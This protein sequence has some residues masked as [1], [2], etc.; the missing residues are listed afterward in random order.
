MS[1]EPRRTP[2]FGVCTRCGSELLS[3]APPKDDEINP[4]STGH[5]VGSGIAR[6]LCGPL[7]WFDDADRATAFIAA[8]PSSGNAGS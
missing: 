3:H 4:A 5:I 2:M 8:K 7:V 6:S 1:T